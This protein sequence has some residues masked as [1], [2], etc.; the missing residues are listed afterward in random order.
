M[1]NNPL[2]KEEARAL[3][4]I[5]REVFM[6]ANDPL[7][8]RY[9]VSMELPLNA[10]LPDDFGSASDLAGFIVKIIEDNDADPLT[11]MVDLV[12]I[13]GDEESIGMSIPELKRCIE[14]Y[15]KGEKDDKETKH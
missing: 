2:S 12:K 9:R 4:R 10:E 6:V 14:T 3:I 7:Y 13:H 15:N 11:T 8:F 1:K 5:L